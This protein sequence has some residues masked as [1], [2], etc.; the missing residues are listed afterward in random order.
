[1]LDKVALQSLAEM[2]VGSVFDGVT[3]IERELHDLTRWG[4]IYRE[5]LGHS[6]RFY[7]TFYEV[8]ATEMQDMEPYEYE[9][10]AIQLA[11]VYPVEKISYQRE[12]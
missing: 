7:E 1:M 11:E 9:D 5:I 4:V 3:L 12:L 8:G 2:K 10:D 6:G